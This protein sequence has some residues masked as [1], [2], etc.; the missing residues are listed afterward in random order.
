MNVKDIN[1]FPFIT[2]PEKDFVDKAL[3][4]L[5]LIGGIDSNDKSLIKSKIAENELNKLGK[6]CEDNIKYD[7]STLI[8]DV[9]RLMIKFPLI[10]RLARI[11]ILANKVY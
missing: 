4:H 9:G 6:T 10:P 8:T 1:K 7:D 11:L 2:K 3:R 5:L